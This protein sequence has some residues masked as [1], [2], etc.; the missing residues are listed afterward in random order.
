MHQMAPVTLTEPGFV[1]QSLRNVTVP[2]GRDV[3]LSCTVKH[4]D[5]HK[6]AWI[7]F[8]R[9]AILTV[10]NSVITRNPRIKVS[11][12]GHR[13]WNLHIKNVQ[14]SDQGAYMCQINTSKAKTR[15]GYLNVV[16]PPKIEDSLTSSDKVRTEGSNVTLECSAQG[17]PHPTVTWKREDGADIN[18]DKSRNVSVPMVDGSVLNLVKVSRLDMGA[19]MCI[20]SNGVPPA[21]SKRIHLGIDF[22]PMMWVPAQQISAIRGAPRAKLTCFVEAHP[23]A[24]TYWEKDRKMIQQSKRHKMVTHKGTPSYKIHMELKIRNI[25]ANDFGAY[26][27]VAKNPRGSTDGEI[28]LTEEIVPTTTSLSTTTTHTSTQTTDNLPSTTT[29]VVDIVPKGDNRRRSKEDAYGTEGEG[30]RKRQKKQRRKKQ[31]QKQETSRGPGSAA[32]L[33]AVILVAGFGISL[34]LGSTY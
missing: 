1:G 17:S 9:S 15:L 5:G 16:V 7:H 27:C 28:T 31:R 12:E 13:T 2:E 20:A 23:E 32:N 26:R 14:R 19:Y 10:Q 24:L 4:L 11:H 29:I 18:I 22:P 30:K 25:Q 8:D 33:D 3:V 6:V 34:I 21:V